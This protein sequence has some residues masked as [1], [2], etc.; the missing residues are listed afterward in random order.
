MHKVL[1]QDADYLSEKIALPNLN[2]ARILVTG[3]TGLIGGSI[4]NYFNQLLRSGKYSFDVDALSVQPR[5]GT[6]E[7]HHRIK[8][9]SGDL[10]LG[11]NRFTLKK[12]D[13]IIHAA[14][15]GQP[16]KFISNT[17][18]TLALN[19]PVVMDLT[20]LLEASGTFLYLSTSEIYSNS[21]SSP[22]TEMDFGHVPIESSRSGYVYGKIFGEVALLQ[23][24]SKYRI[25]IGR[26]ALS[27]GPGT[28][29]SDSRVLNQLIQRGIV[30]HRIE[31]A[32]TGDA[33]RT[34]CYVRDTV[35]ML[36]TITF[37]GQS[38][39]YNIGG[40]SKVTIRELG[41]GISKIL[42]VPFSYPSVSKNYLEAPRQVELD[43]SKYRREFGDI[44]FMPLQQGL[45]R[46]IEWQA[47][48]LY[49]KE[50]L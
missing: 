10:S 16:G 34:Y 24:S 21:S 36:L 45:D 7:F 3:S 40:I 13:Y 32:D 39:I 6:S 35:E 18:D 2:N 37:W 4:L 23:L 49:Q 46:T 43:I 41:E 14:T 15:Y 9:Q 50:N 31:L 44:E 11:L 20:T 17:W 1:I 26:I 27:Y 19:G 5:L 42:K 33:I 48:E 47:S 38:E 25:R 29:L 8:F 12:Y 22:N 30:D 28:K